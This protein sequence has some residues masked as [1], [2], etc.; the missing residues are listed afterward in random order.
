M[1]PKKKEKMVVISIENFKIITDFLDTISVPFANTK[2]AASVA[3]AVNSARITEI[4][5]EK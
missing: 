3:E 4:T 5:F 1:E 2:H